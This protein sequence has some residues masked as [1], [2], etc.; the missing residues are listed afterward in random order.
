MPLGMFKGAISQALNHYGQAL[1]A[2]L[3]SVE[4]TDASSP[5]EAKVLHWLQSTEFVQN[6]PEDVEILPQ[7]PIGE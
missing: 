4:Q 7:F 2:K 6:Q 5:M 1:K 3:G